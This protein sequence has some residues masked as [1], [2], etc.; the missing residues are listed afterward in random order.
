M[1]TGEQNGPPC[2]PSATIG[3]TGTGMLTKAYL[4]AATCA[5]GP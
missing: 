1:I 3:D 4:T 2:K 5:R